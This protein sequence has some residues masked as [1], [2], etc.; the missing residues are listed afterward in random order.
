MKQIIILFALMTILHAPASAQDFDKGL[1]AYRAKD[2][3]SA[4]KEWHPLA[5]QGNANAQYNLGLIYNIG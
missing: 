1:A 2:Y 4:L 3:S 5:K